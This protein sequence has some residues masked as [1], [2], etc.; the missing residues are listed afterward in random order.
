M[1][2]AKA[3][4]QRYSEL[5]WQTPGPFKLHKQTENMYDKLFYYLV[6]KPSRRCRRRRKI[7]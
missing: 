6:S 2:L 5:K 1:K 4:N 3:E 7:D